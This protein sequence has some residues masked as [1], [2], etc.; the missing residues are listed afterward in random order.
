MRL[1]KADTGRGRR[2]LMLSR[3]KDILFFTLNFEG[4]QKVKVQDRRLLSFPGFCRLEHPLLI[5]C[6]ITVAARVKLQIESYIF[7]SK[8]LIFKIR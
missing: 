7:T 3:P 5:L 6:F 8:I 2:S 1:L 4:K